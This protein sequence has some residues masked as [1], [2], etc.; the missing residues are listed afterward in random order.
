[1]TSNPP[2]PAAKRQR[3]DSWDDLDDDVDPYFLRIRDR[4]AALRANGLPVPDEEPM[5]NV[6]ESHPERSSRSSSVSSRGCSPCAPRVA[7]PSSAA[8]SAAGRA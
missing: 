8:A 1:M 5:V 4:R 2:E 6:L 3:T 7:S